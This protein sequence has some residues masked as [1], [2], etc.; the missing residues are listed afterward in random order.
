MELG[1]VG[2]ADLLKALLTGLYQNKSKAIGTS[3]G[4]VRNGKVQDTLNIS[5]YFCH[6]NPNGRSFERR[7]RK[8]INRWQRSIAWEWDKRKRQAAKGLPP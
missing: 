5:S 4:I 8:V 1:R 7:S 2:Y 3:S 6:Q